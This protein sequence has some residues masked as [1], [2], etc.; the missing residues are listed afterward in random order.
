[1]SRAVGCWVE[2]PKYK[3]WYYARRPQEGPDLRELYMY[4]WFASCQLSMGWLLLNCR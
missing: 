4:M 3:P 1:M 2:Y